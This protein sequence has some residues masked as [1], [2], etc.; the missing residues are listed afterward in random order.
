MSQN[1]KIMQLV[2]IVVIIAVSVL[3]GL[4][5]L[6][7]PKAA[8]ADA[9]LT[10]FSAE[11]AM[12]HV[13]AITQKPH[14]IGSPEHARVRE[15]IIA[16]LEAIGLSPEVQKTTVAGTIGAKNRRQSVD[17]AQHRGK[18]RWYR[19]RQ[20]HWPW[21]DTTIPCQRHRGRVTTPQLSPQCWKPLVPLSQPRYYETM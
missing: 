1:T 15:Y 5:S 19:A 8:P 3:I 16:Q 17:S 10:D 2:V 12:D 9:P 20:S 11:R 4:H 14:P 18:N 7:P 21:L 6:L 13:S